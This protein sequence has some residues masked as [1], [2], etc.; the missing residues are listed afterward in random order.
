MPCPLTQN[1][2]LKD[3]LT[4]A[5]VE[6]WLVTPFAN[7][8]TTTLTANVVTAITK[9]LA[10]KSYA[11]ETEQSMWSYTGAGTNANGTKA[12]DWSATIKTNGLNTLDQQ[13]LDTLLSNKVVLIAKM[14]N[15]E[16][17]MLGRTFGS[18]A[19]DSAFE[20][21][22]AMGDFQGTTLTVKGRSNAPAVK[23]DTAIIA[24]LLTV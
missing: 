7:V 8:L 3:C 18:T 10:W 4:T 12:Y 11:Q 5:G 15:G 2:V 22:T 6:S 13:E 1:Y 9:T 17:W 23:V 24:A 14:Y 20:S 21:G 19:I 16:Y